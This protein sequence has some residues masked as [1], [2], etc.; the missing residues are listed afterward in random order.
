MINDNERTWTDADGT[1]FSDFT[2]DFQLTA[3]AGVVYEAIGFLR[4]LHHFFSS[5]CICVLR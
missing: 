5:T 2:A 4:M 3:I 1:V